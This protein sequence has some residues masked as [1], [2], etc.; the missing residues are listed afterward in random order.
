MPLECVMILIDNS[1]YSRNGDVHPNRYQA[2]L[3]AIGSLINLKT[4]D[5][6]ETS[7]GLMTIAGKNCQILSTP[8]NE[9]SRLY[10]TYNNI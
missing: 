5:N 10:S 2:Q 9:A 7:V 3:D 8:T 1:V 4:N 6:M